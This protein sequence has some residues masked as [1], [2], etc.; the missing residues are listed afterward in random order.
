MS[1]SFLMEEKKNRLSFLTIFFYIPQKKNTDME[2]ILQFLQ[3][4]DI[5]FKSFNKN[6]SRP[7]FRSIQKNANYMGQSKKPI[8]LEHFEIINHFLSSKLTVVAFF[9]QNQFWNKK[10]SSTILTLHTASSN[11]ADTIWIKS[12]NFLF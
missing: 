2:K 7:L 12:I 11:P 3:Q 5:S 9:Y 8:L 10:R 6:M 1:H 4:Y